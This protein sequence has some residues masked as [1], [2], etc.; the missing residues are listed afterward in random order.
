MVIMVSVGVHLLA[1]ALLAVIKITEVLQKE[2]EFEA[3]PLEAVE[4]P[5]PPPPPPPT[6]RTTQKSMPRP[7]PLAAQNPQNLDVPTIEIDR[8]NLNMLSG[9]GFGG[10]LGTIGGGVLDTANFNISA[11]GIDQA[12]TGTIEG[13]FYDFK[14]NKR[15]KPSEN[16]PGKNNDIF[17]AFTSSTPWSV[18]DQYDY[19]TPKNGLFLRIV[20]FPG[21]PDSDA[22]AAFGAPDSK[23][24]KWAAH[25]SGEVIGAKTG[26]FRLVG[27][28]DNYFIVGLNDEV[29]LDA[30]DRYT[31]PGTEGKS[32]VR[33]IDVP[34]K[35]GPKFFQGKTFRV[36]KGESYRIDLLMGDMGGIFSAGAMVLE[37][38]ETFDSSKIFTEYPILCFG[39]PSPAEKELFPFCSDKVFRA[40]IFRTP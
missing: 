20:L 37:E 11:F 12:V 21:M 40:T 6:T 29:I 23:A 17:E 1:G 22:G 18:P 36:R 15:K 2:P 38:D 27:W 32:G 4:P 16:P 28:G 39:D 13:A 24:G 31:T 30:S 8:T 9:R 33:G 14:L 25:Y 3:P 10:G 34:G 5:L 7:Q 19:Y 35:P 26:N